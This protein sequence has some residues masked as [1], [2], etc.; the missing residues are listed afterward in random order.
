MLDN[1]SDRSISHAPRRFRRVI[2]V[3]LGMDT[4]DTIS[5][6]KN[7][8]QQRDFH[9]KCFNLPAKT[10]GPRKS[11]GMPQFSLWLAPNEAAKA[12]VRARHEQERDP[13]RS[14]ADQPD[15]PRI[16]KMYPAS[17]NCSSRYRSM[18]TLDDVAQEF[19]RRPDVV[20]AAAYLNQIR[21][22]RWSG[23]LTHATA[24]VFVLLVLRLWIDRE[25]ILSFGAQ[26]MT[27]VI[28]LT[29]YASMCGRH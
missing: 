23:I 29:H 22:G 7:G 6:Q 19:V 2:L 5:M 1:A 14:S 15:H 27:L 20:Q 17:P 12:E 25:E 24:T 3:E 11:F 28:D 10:R 4:L 9:R 8:Q 26:R 21:F 13:A 18:D 16:S